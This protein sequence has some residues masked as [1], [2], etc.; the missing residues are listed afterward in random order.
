MTKEQSLKALQPGQYLWSIPTKP[1]GLT[2]QPAISSQE[3]LTRAG[4]TESELRRSPFPIKY[5]DIN[6][7][8]D[9]DRAKLK[10]ERS[11]RMKAL[12]LSRKLRSSTSQ[13]EIAA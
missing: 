6:D 4:L 12:N 2:Y 13:E 7:K 1:Y 5:R 8:S 10:K 3:A 9:K 11:K